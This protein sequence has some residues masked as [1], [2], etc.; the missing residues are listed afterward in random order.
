MSDPVRPEPSSVDAS[1]HNTDRL[2]AM[3]TAIDRKIDDTNGAAES[4]FMALES[5]GR[6]H[7][8][9]LDE[10]QQALAPWRLDHEHVLSPRVVGARDGAD[11]VAVRVDD[12]AAH[13]VGEVQLV[14]VGLGQELALDADLAAAQCDL[15]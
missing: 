5:L 8:H 1:N 9:R 11:G 2:A 13:E 12:R 4:R 3:L 15:L 10:R 7:E 14:R 6:D